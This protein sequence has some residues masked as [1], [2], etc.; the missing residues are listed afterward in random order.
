MWSENTLQCKK[1]MT[2]TSRRND[3]STK[4]EPQKHTD[5]R[6]HLYETQMQAKAV[7]GVRSQDTGS[8]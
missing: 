2:P 1:E 5:F 8:H 4:K 3:L 7:H 6:F